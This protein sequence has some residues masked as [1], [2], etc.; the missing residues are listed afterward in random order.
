M[1]DLDESDLEKEWAET[2]KLVKVKMEKAAALIKGAIKIAK[3]HN[4][5]LN[6]LYDGVKPL[7][8][9]MEEAGWQT[10]SLMC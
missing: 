10:S 1:N 2:E 4:L 7:L 8:D 3:K 6:E 9:A 5:E